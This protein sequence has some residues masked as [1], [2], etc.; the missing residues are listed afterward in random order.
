M[1]SVF[2][3]DR[4]GRRSVLFVSQAGACAFAVLLTTGYVCSINDLIVL[5][6]FSHVAL[7]A[8]GMGP[9]PWTLITELS[10]VYVSSSIGFAATAT[11][12]WAMNFLIRQCFPN[13]QGY[14]FLIFAIVALIT[15]LFTYISIPETK[16][17]SIKDIYSRV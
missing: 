15:L 12:N 13:I 1:I 5:S 2:L 10:P 11:M 6:I 4:T 17:R 8:V 9:V 3:I 14:S 16:G 7:L